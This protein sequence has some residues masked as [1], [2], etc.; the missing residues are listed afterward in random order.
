[1]CIRD[2]SLTK[3]ISNTSSHDDDNIIETPIDNIVISSN[4]TNI[5]TELPKAYIEVRNHSH[6]L[7]IGD[8]TK[9][10]QTRSKLNYMTQIAFISLIEPKNI[11]EACA[12]IFGQ[13]QCK[14]S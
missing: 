5:S 10:V 11:K 7:V 12:M 8:I 6:D 9:G 4:D 13:L 1:M 14:K 3:P 2:R